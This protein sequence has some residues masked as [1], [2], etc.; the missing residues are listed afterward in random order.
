[1]VVEPAL[2]TCSSI[3]DQTRLVVASVPVA[4]VMS[5]P[6]VVVASV[7]V[8]VAS[9]RAMMPTIMPAPSGKMM[10]PVRAG[11]MVRRAVMASVASG[12]RSVS[13]M[14]RGIA[15][16]EMSA[17]VRGITVMAVPPM[18]VAGIT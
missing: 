9:A 8:M 2:K 11:Y 6:M 7:P 5:V 12:T 17:M 14:S 3:T 16:L 15:V 18:M 13:V 10:V 4:A 1:M